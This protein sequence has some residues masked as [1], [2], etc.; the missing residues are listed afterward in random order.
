MNEL[1]DRIMD[2]PVRQRVLLLVGSVFL[3]FFLYGY[4]LYLPRNSE[5]EEKEE[6]LVALEKDR[7]R[8]QALV[9]NLPQL[10]QE[11]ADLNAAL[12]KAVAQ[13]P[14]TKEIP[15][16]LSGISAVA[17]ESGLEIQQFRQKQE[18]YQDFYAEVPVEILVKGTYWQVEQ[19]FKKVADLT[20]IVNVGD[21][22]I[23]AP[24]LIENDPVQLQTSCAA[25]TFRFLDEEER[26][27]IKK[28]REKKEKGA[29]K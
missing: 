3:L 9:S 28:E 8:K 29:K 1:F 6:N 18:N 4:L 7:D 16:L 22:G 15:D 24:T 20:R 27:R 25:T 17:R 26:E 5:I 12:K 23:K 21:I 19:F 10:R 14:D 11:V 13:L 2:M